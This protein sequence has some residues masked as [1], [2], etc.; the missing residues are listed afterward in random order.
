MV[1]LGGRFNRATS[2]KAAATRMRE[3]LLSEQVLSPD[4]VFAETISRDT[5]ENLREGFALLERKG[6][7][8]RRAELIIVSHPWH[9]ERI[10]SILK[11]IYHRS[12]RLI[13]AWHCL[14]WKERA[15]EI[16]LYFY[17]K[18]DPRGEGWFFGWIRRR[19][20]RSGA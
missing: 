9:E 15:T 5:F 18:I 1:C 14:N 7:D 8:H 16:G 19:R 17:T 6:I 3:W 2:T 10:Q 12:A 11:R 13:P 4:R 20:A